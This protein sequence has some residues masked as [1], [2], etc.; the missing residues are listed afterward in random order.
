MIDS[1]GAGDDGVATVGSGTSVLRVAAR[2]QHS[3]FP[4][5]GLYS[6]L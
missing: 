5:D 1:E 6:R 2:R 4:S 3:S